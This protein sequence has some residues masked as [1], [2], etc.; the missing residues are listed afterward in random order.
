MD[1]GVRGDAAGRSAA[2]VRGR[3]RVPLR[4]V[5]STAWSRGSRP[6]CRA[7]GVLS[8]APGQPATS[9]GPVAGS[10]IAQRAPR[11]AAGDE[12]HAGFHN[13]PA[14]VG[15]HHIWGVARTRTPDRSPRHPP[16]TTAARRAAVAD[17]YQRDRGRALASAQPARPRTEPRPHLQDQGRP[18]M[19]D[20]DA[21]VEAA[22]A[23]SRLMSAL[24]TAHLRRA[25]RSPS[26]APVSA[27][28]L[29]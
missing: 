5:R 29:D 24:G 22:A 10:R 7:R 26:S 8:N 15:S 18:V 19:T 27:P 17:L 14:A 13:V 21:L 25:D 28:R 20:A 12:L 16:G 6:R 9:L 23:A 11:C 4:P 1:D 2:P 3:A